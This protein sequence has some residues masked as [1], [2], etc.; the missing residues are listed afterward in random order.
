SKF[1]ADSVRKGEF[2]IGL[3]YGFTSNL[4]GEIVYNPD[5]SQIESDAAQV[6]VNSSSA[7]FYP[8]KRPF[9]LTGTDIFNS[10]IN[11]VYT[12]MINDP[13]LA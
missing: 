1:I 9:F 12:R 5:F 13:L 11:V 7:L 6:D 4:T 2:G 8:E 10:Y 3:K